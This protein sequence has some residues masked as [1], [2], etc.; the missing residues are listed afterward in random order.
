MSKEIVVNPNLY[1]NHL[2][3]DDF[4]IP[5]EILLYN[6]QQT[7]VGKPFWHQVSLENFPLWPD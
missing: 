1:S 7:N 3:S 5:F 4:F 2:Y 6:R